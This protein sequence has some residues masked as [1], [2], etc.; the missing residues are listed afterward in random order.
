MR[1]LLIFVLVTTSLPAATKLRMHSA[2]SGVSSYKEAN[3]NLGTGL[4][5][6]VTNSAASGTQIQW[7]ATGGGTAGGATS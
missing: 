2:A 1:N 3:P 4:T 7:T 5:T 6:S